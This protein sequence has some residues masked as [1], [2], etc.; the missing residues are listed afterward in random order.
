MGRLR[1]NLL[2][3]RVLRLKLDK[4]VIFTRITKKVDYELPDVIVWVYECVYIGL[5]FGR[6][7]RQKEQ[8]KGDKSGHHL[9]GRGG[10]DMRLLIK[11]EFYFLFQIN[12]I[13]FYFQKKKKKKS[14]LLIINLTFISN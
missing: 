3:F 12:I 10:P 13:I 8:E 1:S 14:K 2:K 9:M 4:T 7:G 11:N 5:C 6:N